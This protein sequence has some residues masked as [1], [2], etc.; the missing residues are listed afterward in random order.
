MIS[1]LEAGAV[2]PPYLIDS[3]VVGLE[4]GAGA[5]ELSRFAVALLETRDDAVL[6]ALAE[7]AAVVKQCR[8]VTDVLQQRALR[9]GNSE[10]AAADFR[11]CLDGYLK[12]GQYRDAE[13]VLDQ[14]ETL[15]VQGV[16]AA[17]FQDLLSKE[18]AYQPA[19][20][21]EDAI[22]ARARCFEAENR[23]EDA[24][25]LLQPL[26]HRYATEGDLHDAT[27]VL[28]R[29]RGYGLPSE[30]YEQEANRVQALAEQDLLQAADHDQ[31]SMSKAALGT[32]RVLFVGGDERQAKN[33]EAVRRQVKER[34]PHVTL[35][36]I[37]P[38]WNGNWNHHLDRV[39]AQLE[40]HDG[41]V[42]MRFIRTELGKQIRKRC[43]KPWRFCWGAGR[44]VMSDAII[45]AADA[46]NST[47]D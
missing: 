43:D 38:G 25:L 46:A 33:E 9:L 16:G 35:T 29:V 39:N 42:L 10:V 45:A 28:D 34:A 44:R 24:L 5:E 30:Y 37:Y 36:F 19:W 40:K 6:N 20:G 22:I 11:I 7:S 13:E 26:V 21:P 8:E 2:F 31:P 41:L 32:V 18:N 23:L 1:A 14:L 15:A 4:I 27:G 3:A 47:A 12:A 17:E